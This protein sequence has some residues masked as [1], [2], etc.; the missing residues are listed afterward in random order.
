MG[1]E[2]WELTIPRWRLPVGR[3]LGGVHD[4]SPKLLCPFHIWLPLPRTSR[5]LKTDPGHR[6]LNRAWFLCSRSLSGGPR[7]VPGILQ[8][9]VTDTQRSLGRT[10][11]TSRG[12]VATNCL[13]PGH[14][15]ACKVRDPNSFHFSSC[16]SFHLGEY[17]RKKGAYSRS[18]KD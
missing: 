6:G 1:Q 8:S 5:E 17:E 2:L 14:S 9:Q 13:I 3:F 16:S 10:S 18:T 12:S 11:W 15:W 7:E 4:R